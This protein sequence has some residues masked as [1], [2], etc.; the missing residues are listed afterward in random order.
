VR[1]GTLGPGRSVRP[2]AVAAGQIRLFVD[3]NCGIDISSVTQSDQNR[4]AETLQ[5]RRSNRPPYQAT[6]ESV[7]YLG[8]ADPLPQPPAKQT[9]HTEE[10]RR[11][12]QARGRRADTAARRRAPRISAVATA[13]GTASRPGVRRVTT[14]RLDGGARSSASLSLRHWKL[15]NAS[16]RLTKDEK[17]LIVNS[18]AV[19]AGDGTEE[20]QGGLNGRRPGRNRAARR[21]PTLLATRTAR[22]RVPRAADLQGDDGAPSAAPNGRS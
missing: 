3:R 8:V 5:L 21:T 20:I 22:R 16:G 2:H 11:S 14:R 19:L 1:S 9:Q 18:N 12:R 17:P 15:A 13:R 7:F 10:T 6:G 4:H